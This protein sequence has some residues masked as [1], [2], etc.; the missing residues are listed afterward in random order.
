MKNFKCVLEYRIKLNKH[1][2]M[3]HVLY[4][5]IATRNIKKPYIVEELK[6]KEAITSIQVREF[7]FGE[8]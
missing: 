4:H 8:G 5:T 7:V 2:D 3:K 6:S 1:N